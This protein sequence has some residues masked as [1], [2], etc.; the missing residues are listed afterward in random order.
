MAKKVMNIQT[1]TELEVFSKK[2]KTLLIKKTIK[3]ATVVVLTGDLGA[4]KTTFVQN[5]GREFGISEIMPS[6][7]FGIMKSYP[8][9]HQHFTTLV[10]MDAYRI[11]EIA[12]LGPLCFLELLAE[13]GVLLVVEWGERIVSALPS[14]R[15]ELCIESE[16]SGLRTIRVNNYL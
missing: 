2:I 1:L 10:H 5:L 14:E 13:K 15:L 8:L 6:P 3:G 9:T 12:E 4:G 16:E 11:E 7:T